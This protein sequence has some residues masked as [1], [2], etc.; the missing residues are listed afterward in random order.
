MAATCVYLFGLRSVSFAVGWPQPFPAGSPAA[1]LSQAWSVPVNSFWFRTEGS[2]APSSLIISPSSQGAGLGTSPTSNAVSKW[3]G[4]IH[5]R[6]GPSWGLLAVAL[7]LPP[8]ADLLCFLVGLWLFLAADIRQ[9][10]LFRMTVAATMPKH[11][12]GT[13]LH[14]VKYT[15]TKWL[16]SY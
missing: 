13:Q 4:L 1:G 9:E 12:I 14:S 7:S 2:S 15:A 10:Q 16:A 3:A 6:A 11:I 8:L 5:I